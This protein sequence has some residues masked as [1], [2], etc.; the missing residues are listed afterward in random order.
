MKL[1]NKEV[2]LSPD[3]LSAS[4]FKSPREMENMLKTLYENMQAAS[5]K[6]DFEKAA[7]IRDII[8]GLKAD[9]LE[10][11]LLKKVQGK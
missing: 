6:M 4:Q 5:K 11:K 9:Y 8:K 3:K 1:L 2:D 10:L 7:Y